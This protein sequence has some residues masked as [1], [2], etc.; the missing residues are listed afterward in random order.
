[1]VRHHLYMTEER[2]DELIDAVEAVAAQG[3]PVLLGKAVIAVDRSNKV[4]LQ[5]VVTGLQERDGELLLTLEQ[6]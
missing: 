2:A 1:M 5:G 3:Q 4:I 6:P